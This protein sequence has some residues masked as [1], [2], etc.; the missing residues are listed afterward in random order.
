[1]PR[2]GATVQRERH[3]LAARCVVTLKPEALDD[4]SSGMGAIAPHDAQDGSR[5]GTH[6]GPPRR[7]R[8]RDVLPRGQVQRN[9]TKTI[10]IFPRDHGCMWGEAA[11][12]GCPFSV[13]VSDAV[14]AAVKGR[15]KD[16]NVITWSTQL[17]CAAKTINVA[18][19]C[20]IQC[21]VYDGVS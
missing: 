6:T 18:V 19:A 14:Q 17:A 5:R 12:K 8:R 4:G 11:V 3:A 9:V 10:P 20:S 13:Y 16:G 7:H 2:V 21:H 15:V 1:M